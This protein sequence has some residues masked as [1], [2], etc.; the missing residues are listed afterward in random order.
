MAPPSYTRIT[1]ETEM[2]KGID[3]LIREH[4]AE[5]VLGYFT[6]ME[7]TVFL[8]EHGFDE[9]DTYL[10][11]MDVHKIPIVR[12]NIKTR[13]KIEDYA[14]DALRRGQKGDMFFEK[15]G[16]ADFITET[17]D[18]DQ[19]GKDTL[20]KAYADAVARGME[21]RTIIGPDFKR[22]SFSREN[23]NILLGLIGENA[24][25]YSP[26][27]THTIV[28]KIGDKTHAI[29]WYSRMKPDCE[30]IDGK[31]QDPDTVVYNGFELSESIEAHGP[32]LSGLQDK[33]NKMWNAAK[34]V[35]PELDAPEMTVQL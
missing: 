15:C 2:K 21:I 32:F 14:V 16:D 1:P 8:R 5:A 11:F 26:D 28:R 9:V 17:T 35:K 3:A 31:P 24:L 20:Q 4:G 22:D 25:R 27:K 30:R 6:T 19:V 33:L 18:Y 34:A 10:H 29:V 13:R 12:D 7:T 23:A